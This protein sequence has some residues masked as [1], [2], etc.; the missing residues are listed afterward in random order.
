MAV[1]SKG[2]A[3][4]GNF[5]RFLERPAA[6]SERQSQKNTQKV[7]NYPVGQVQRGAILGLAEAMVGKPYVY[8]ATTVVMTQTAEVLR[9][10]RE[11]WLKHLNHVPALINALKQL[12]LN[13]TIMYQRRV[14]NIISQT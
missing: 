11:V 2:G 12:G 4:I 13:Q 7:K 6:E 5:A 14:G 8:D 10:E 3:E 9:I 1:P